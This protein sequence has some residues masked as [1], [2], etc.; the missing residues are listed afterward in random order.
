MKAVYFF[1]KMQN[2]L[3]S[4]LIIPF[5]IEAFPS[6]NH[7]KNTN[8]DL[9]HTNYGLKNI[10]YDFKNTNNDFK[11]SR[12][13]K[14][15]YLEDPYYR[16]PNQNIEMEDYEVSGNVHWW[17]TEEE[18]NSL[19][20][21]NNLLTLK[22]LLTLNQQLNSAVCKKYNQSCVEKEILKNNFEDSGICVSGRCLPKGYKKL[23]LP[24]NK[25][26]HVNMSL[27]SSH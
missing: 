26:T 8:Y 6:K 3:A 13:L 4:L 27:V 22:S 21:L 1:S 10:N 5:W 16:D 11:N 20:S 24:N 18:E 17:Q 19:L 25:L 15:S 7:F 2:V 9:K 14:T 23:E 12:T